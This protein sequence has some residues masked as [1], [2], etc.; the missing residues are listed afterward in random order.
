LAFLPGANKRSVVLC[1]RTGRLKNAQSLCPAK[2]SRQYFTPSAMHAKAG[3]D[4]LRLVDVAAAIRAEAQAHNIEVDWPS[5]IE[6]Y[7]GCASAAEVDLRAGELLERA[8]ADAADPRAR[9]FLVDMFSDAQ[10]D[11]W[12]VFSERILNDEDERIYRAHLESAVLGYAAPCPISTARKLLALHRAGRLSVIKGVRQVTLDDDGKHYLVAHDF[13]VEKATNLVNTTG[14]LDRDVRSPHQPKLIRD[15]VGQGLLQSDERGGIASKGAA[16]DMKT[17]R[18]RG[19][20]SIFLANMLLWGPGF[21]TSSA[22][23]MAAVME[24]MLSEMFPHSPH[25]T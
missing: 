16:V 13:G 15:L 5:V 8:I 6:P 11:I 1:S 3:A 24:R 19:A 9:N 20:R 18:V 2:L 22:Y 21:F 14:S 23:M 10:I 12:D 25:A 7:A 4:G 17:F